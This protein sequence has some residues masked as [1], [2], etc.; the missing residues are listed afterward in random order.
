MES[1]VAVLMASLL[2]VSIFS[3]VAYLT[4]TRVSVRPDALAKSIAEEL[5]DT[6]GIR[7]VSL[8][9]PCVVS[10]NQT[11][12]VVRA[13]GVMG[14]CTLNLDR[15]VV[16][17]SASGLLVRIYGNSTHIWINRE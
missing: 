3:V 17:S 15:A 8:G 9:V 1:A 11:H 16:P 12:V 13:Y 14:Y 6:H 2:L 4:L 5:E 10:I 7:V